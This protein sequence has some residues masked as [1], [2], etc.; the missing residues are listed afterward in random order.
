MLWYNKFII[1]VVLQVS[2]TYSK[3]NKHHRGSSFYRWTGD[4]IFQEE[5]I[6]EV[7]Q[8][9]SSQ[10]LLRCRRKDGCRDVA[11]TDEGKCLLLGSPMSSV[12]KNKPVKGAQRLS[13]AIK[14]EDLYPTSCKEA[15]EWN[16]TE[17]GNNKYD[18][19][20]DGEVIRVKCG[21]KYAGR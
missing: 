13:H 3:H 20:Y 21:M 15:L 17:N 19:I 4:S 12:L 5:V 6:E 1:A 10:C 7:K 14:Q 9:S 2:V 16:T 11:L 18:V 8:A